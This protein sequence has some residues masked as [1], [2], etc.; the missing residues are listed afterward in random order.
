MKW[1]KKI[2]GINPEEEIVI[3]DAR[4]KNATPTSEL[5]VTSENKE[6]AITDDNMSETSLRKLTKNQLE[7]LA[8]SKLGVDLDK[9]ELKETLI[10]QILTI[11]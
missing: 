9:R 10:K 4:F 6:V 3:N 11:Q 7:E 8:K 2:F 1:I 5:V